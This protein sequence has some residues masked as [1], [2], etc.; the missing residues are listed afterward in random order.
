MAHTQKTLVIGE[1]VL[2]W[3]AAGSQQ[4]SGQARQDKWIDLL[5]VPGLA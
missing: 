1:G 5:V 3:F 2:Y 4:C